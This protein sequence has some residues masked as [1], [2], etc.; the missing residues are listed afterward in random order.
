MRKEDFAEVLGDINE[1]HVAEARAEGK[2]KMPVWVKWC[3]VAACLCLA[4]LI[5]LPHVPASGDEKNPPHA[6]LLPGTE[7][8]HSVKVVPGEKTDTYLS[9]DVIMKIGFTHAGVETKDVQ[10]MMLTMDD[11]TKPFH[12]DLKF[13][14]G[15]NWHEYEIDAVT[16]EILAVE[17]Q[18]SAGNDM[19]AKP[20]IPNNP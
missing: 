16:G 12:F 13:F 20:I 8:E 9:G 3:A 10:N 14:A 2:A 19:P 18:P 5:T 17:I 7:G 15:G 6:P 4:L 11:D 1:K